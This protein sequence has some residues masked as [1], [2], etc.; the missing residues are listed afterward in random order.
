[1]PTIVN[2]PPPSS[3]NSSDFSRTLITLGLILLLVV[4]FLAYGL[5]AIRQSG[6]YSPPPQNI[7]LNVNPQNPPPVQPDTQQNLDLNINPPQDQPPATTVP[8]I[9]LNQLIPTVAP[10]PSGTTP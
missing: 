8:S 6:V 5:P 9:D 4:I 3:D 7:D 10:Q 1:M 2:N